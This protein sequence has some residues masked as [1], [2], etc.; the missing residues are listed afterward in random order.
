MSKRFLLLPYWYL[1]FTIG[2]GWFIL[3]PLDPAIAAFLRVDPT[4]ILVVV[5]AYGYAM[6]V[7]GLVAGAISLK[8]T[9]RT[10]L[11]IAIFLSAIG[12][13]GRALSTDYTE[14]L[15]FALLAA[16][17]YPLALAPV[18]SLSASIDKEHSNLIIG[19]SVGIL[20]IGLAAGSFSGP[21]LLK[22]LGLRDTLLVPVV[23][24]VL[25]AAIVPIAAKDYPKNYSGRNFKGTFK[26]GMIKNWWIGFTI[27]SLA[28][29]FGA[30]SAT[31]LENLH[32][33]AILTSISISG[34]L[35]GLGF[36]GSG[37]G[38]ATVP[39]IFEKIKRLK[40]GLVAMASASLVFVLILL[41][42][43][44]YSRIIILMEIGFFFFGF[45]GNA[46]WS[47]SLTSVTFYTEDP[48]KSGF[49]T[50]MFSVIS[51]IGVS[52]VPVFLGSLFFARSSVDYA[53]VIAAG[54]VVIAALLS[55]FLLRSR[56]ISSS[57]EG[58]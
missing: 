23:L 57:G 26:K 40:D 4:S 37:L 41:F 31:V 42:S 46:F 33:F 29:M 17:A 44:V 32:G 5:D 10:A 51:N 6:V 24:G 22:S 7:L 38:A 43:L 3:A 45:F 56:V 14:F 1:L 39:A 35:G 20:F 16:S 53:F 8:V 13:L 27:A 21:S 54:M 48:A 28:V 11:Y 15:I 34:I 2:F 9:V 36:L 52:V 30:I 25:A 49:A 18:G 50:S 47:M 12:L 55:P 19:M 58:N